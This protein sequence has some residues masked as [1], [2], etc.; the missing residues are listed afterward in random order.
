M[1]SISRL[2]RVE[3]AVHGLTILFGLTSLA[4]VEAFLRGAGHPP[5]ASWSL[6]AALG[7][8][9]I[10]VSIALTRI[11]SSERAAFRALLTVGLALA[12]IS[13]ALQSATYNAHLGLLWSIMLGFGVPVVGEIGLS[14]AAALFASAQRREELR[15]VND[16]IERAIVANLDGAI[17]AFDPS[18][19]RGR[20]DR[21]LN[22][23]AARAVDGV[24]ANLLAV[25]GQAA[26]SAPEPVSVERAGADDITHNVRTP[27]ELAAARR[28]KKQQ[29]MDAVWALIEQGELSPANLADRVGVSAKTLGRYIEE[30]RQAG[31]DVVV[32]GVVKAGV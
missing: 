10:I 7:A 15:T 17:D 32:N 20:I 22:T 12:L 27:D 16:R 8:A 1:S 2:F 11:S 28:A 9:L 25:Y 18:K 26:D 3:K 21:A 24:T 23:V 29:R 19:I 4:N 30:F 6:A 14:L 13:G 31:R 5:G